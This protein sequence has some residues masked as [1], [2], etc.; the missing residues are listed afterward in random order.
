[1]RAFETLRLD[2]DEQIDVDATT[3]MLLA[4]KPSNWRP[5][6]IR[7]V[8]DQVDD[9]AVE[10]RVIAETVEPQGQRTADGALEDAGKYWSRELFGQLDLLLSR[11]GAAHVADE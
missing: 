1:M 10:I 8:V 6:Y 7:V 11:E 4:H 9:R 3:R 5:E 2:S